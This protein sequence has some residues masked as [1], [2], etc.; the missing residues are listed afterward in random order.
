[1]DGL[2]SLFYLCLA[3][4]LVCLANLGLWMVIPMFSVGIECIY[5]FSL[6]P[7]LGACGFQENAFITVHPRVKIH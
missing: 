7:Q 6:L 5:L 3:D 2:I 1:M 4:F